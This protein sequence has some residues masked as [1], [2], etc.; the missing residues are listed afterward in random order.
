MMQIAIVPVYLFTGVLIERIQE[1]VARL[2]QQYPQV[3][4]AEGGRELPDYRPLGI[5]ALQMEKTCISQQGFTAA[6]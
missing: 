3:S 2:Q 6:A 4:F 1:Q 5:T